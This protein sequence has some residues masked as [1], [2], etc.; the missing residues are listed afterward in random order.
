MMIMTMPP[1]H[2]WD[3]APLLD[4]YYL[5]TYY[6]SFITERIKVI[7]TARFEQPA[8]SRSSRTPRS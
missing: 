6:S 7:Y 5:D 1:S 2:P 3:A 4:T 8:I